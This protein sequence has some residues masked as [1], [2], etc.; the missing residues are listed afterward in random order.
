M[1]EGLDEMFEGQAAAGI[2]G[3]LKHLETQMPMLSEPDQ[4]FVE[5]AL[6][7]LEMGGVLKQADQTRVKQIMQT[8]S[9]AGHNTM[10][11]ALS[12]GQM[13]KSLSTV[14]AKLTE[15]ESR[16]LGGIARKVKVKQPLNEQEL[17]SLVQIYT[18]KGF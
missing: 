14:I 12:V 16:L 2:K 17:A 5:G 8:L 6:Y 9:T 7:T 11:G 1:Y 3:L 18:D 13:L 4:H 15:Q 10:D